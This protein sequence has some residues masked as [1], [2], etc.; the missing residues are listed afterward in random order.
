MHVAC[1]A[2]NID[3]LETQPNAI[4]RGGE[5][6]MY[7]QH[8]A[9]QKPEG[10]CQSSRDGAGA[11][12]DGRLGLYAARSP[13]YSSRVSGFSIAAEAMAVICAWWTLFRPSQTSTQCIPKATW[14]RETRNNQLNPS[15]VGRTENNGRVDR[16]EAPHDSHQLL[17]GAHSLRA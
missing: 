9:L 13:S 1:P 14:V 16:R 11:R 8:A 6:V 17:R 3:I 2:G 10:A 4:K 15:I 12:P 7:L 5:R